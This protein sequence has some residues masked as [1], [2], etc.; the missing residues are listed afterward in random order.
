MGK[1]TRISNV[2]VKSSREVDAKM[3]DQLIFTCEVYISLKGVIFY[4]LNMGH[5]TSHQQKLSR[6]EEHSNSQLSK[7]LDFEVGVNFSMMCHAQSCLL[8]HQK[9]SH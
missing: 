5:T 3:S 8:V 6:E 7:L 1:E 4:I 9:F 2:P